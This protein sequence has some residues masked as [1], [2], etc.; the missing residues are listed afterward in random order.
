LEV[1]LGQGLRGIK[2][3]LWLRDV[4]C[5]ALSLVSCGYLPFD[6]EIRCCRDRCLWPETVRCCIESGETSAT[7]VAKLV[8]N[9]QLEGSTLGTF[10]RLWFICD[11]VAIDLFD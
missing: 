10:D 5:P 6:A 9:V 3:K 11:A 8:S 1:V 2:L 4:V 7:A